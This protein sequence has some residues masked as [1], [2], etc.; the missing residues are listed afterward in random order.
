VENSPDLIIR[1]GRS[2]RYLYVNPAF[3]RLAGLTREQIIGKT[4][5]D[6]GMPREQVEF[7]EQAVHTAFADGS[8]ASIEFE[9][10]SFFGRRFF[11]AQVIPEF[12]R[13]GMIESV[14]VISRDIAERKRAEER[15]RYVSFHDA[16]TGLYNR[17]Y[18]EEELAR[19]D[20]ERALPISIIMGDLNNLKLIN[21]TFGH[22]QGYKLL[23]KI[24]AILRQSC[25]KSDIIARW[26][27]DEFTVILPNTGY[28]AAQEVI[29]RVQAECNQVSDM[30]I[31]PSIALGIGIKREKDTNIYRIIRE[32]EDR[33]YHDKAAT[34]KE[35]LERVIT[36]IL[37][38]VSESGH[39]TE[40]HVR[41]LEGLASA[42]GDTMGLPMSASLRRFRRRRPVSRGCSPIVGSS[43][44]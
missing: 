39:E 27:G 9:L 15:V 25:R 22:Q 36:A 43:S 31:R 4:N 42:L 35:N 10:P 2:M 23:I 26:G 1:I 33:M 38:K 19:L 17:A 20:N 41:R 28:D 18:F 44:T 32:A 11:L 5:R 8:T 6:L 12:N 37:H 21:D 30:V 24:A 3:E 16:V 14:M 29:S 34:A 40:K 13:D 7:W